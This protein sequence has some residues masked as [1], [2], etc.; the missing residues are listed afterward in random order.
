MTDRYDRDGPWADMEIQRKMAGFDDGLEEEP[1][2]QALM[3]EGGNLHMVP[4]GVARLYAEQLVES[5][6]PVT[7]FQVLLSEIL[8]TGI[9]E[10]VFENDEERTEALIETIAAIRALGY[11]DCIR[12]LETF[13]KEGES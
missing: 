13:A 4:E 11:Q 8:D 1:R 10:G 2:W 3:P 9:G 12:D 6:V 5:G 7:D